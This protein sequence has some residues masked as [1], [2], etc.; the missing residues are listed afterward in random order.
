MA[1]M[2]LT[3]GAP[4]RGDPCTAGT[5]LAYPY[6][7]ANIETWN[8]TSYNLTFVETTKTHITT[9]ISLVPTH[10]RTS[11]EQQHGHSGKQRRWS[12]RAVGCCGRAGGDER[13]RAAVCA[14]GE[15]SAGACA[16]RRG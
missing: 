6:L 3:Q 11:T 8:V 16:A 2:Y 1:V 4:Y 12:D 15:R 13:C 9:H 14:G 5:A 10:T 7:G